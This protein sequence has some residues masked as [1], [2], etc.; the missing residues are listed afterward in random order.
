MT[1]SDV[2]VVVVGETPY[3]EGN[4]D[5]TMTGS[6]GMKMVLN[7]ND[8]TAVDR[9]CGAMKCVVLV[10]SGRPM[11][12]SDRL[13][14]MNA[15][16]ASWLPGSEGAGVADV[17]FG[18]VPFTG[19]LPMTWP[20]ALTQEPINVGDATYDPEFPFGWGLRTDSARDR[21]TRAA[22][23]LAGDPEAL[24][25]RDGLTALAALPDWSAR[26]VLLRLQGI[27]RHL[28]QTTA[29]TWTVDDLV[30]S[31]A[32][33]Y[34]Q[35]APITPAASTLSSDA[36]HELLA[37]N[38]ATAIGKLA[39]VAGFAYTET[40]GGVGGSV[41]S[42][43]AL[44][45]GAA[46]SFG[47]FMPGITRDYAASTT[48]TVIS[49]AGDATLSVADPSPTAPGHL[50]NGAFSLPSPLQVAGSVLP[51][52][53][54]TYGAPVSNDIA[55]VAFAQHIGFTDALR[56]GSYAKTLTFTLS[57]TTP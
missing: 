48:A 19:R 53:V 25:A 5:V 42:T 22:A 35:A 51:A 20:R 1:G 56:T 49:T 21:A 32:R 57:T 7:T 36:E 13:S 50:V 23:A 40:T 15:V 37:G 2:G 14:K 24:A 45:L 27:A 6:T 46:P 55:T 26:D 8:A 29:D 10:V 11:I 18:N 3:A 54:K 31:I 38:E 28:D 16:V 34:A 9:V 47:A 30:A 52:T 43:L 12:I 33:D 44:T 17:L 41:P 4:G 39:L